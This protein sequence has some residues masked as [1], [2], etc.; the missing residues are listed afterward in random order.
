ML[1]QVTIFL[2]LIEISTKRVNAV[3]AFWVCL[4]LCLLSIVGVIVVI[5][6]ENSYNFLSE[7]NLIWVVISLVQCVVSIVTF[8]VGLWMMRKDPEWN[9]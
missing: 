1:E 3:K 4:A 7:R 6:L 5:I 9:A 2:I 8:I